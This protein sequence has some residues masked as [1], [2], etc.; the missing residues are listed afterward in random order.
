MK[1]EII[2]ICLCVIALIITTV[3]CDIH[4]ESEAASE[5]SN[6]NVI[7]YKP[8]AIGRDYYVDHGTPE[9][10]TRTDYGSVKISIHGHLYE[11]GWSNVIIQWY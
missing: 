8:I 4:L 3:F 1:N 10:I 5:N 7:I 9:A 6:T 2:A 11:T